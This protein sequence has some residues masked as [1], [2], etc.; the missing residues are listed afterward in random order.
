MYTWAGAWSGLGKSGASMGRLILFSG[1]GLSAESGLPTFRGADGLWNGHKVSEVCDITT[2]RE[3]QELVH[4]FYNARRADAAAA[5]PNAAHRA[6]ADWQ[7][8]YETV[9]LTTN[10]D[11]LLERAGC[12][13]VVHLH[14]SLAEMQ[15][16]ACGGTWACGDEPWRFGDR[17]RAGKRHCTSIR[18]VKPAVVFFHEGAPRYRD[19]HRAFRLLRAEDVVVVV[20][21]SAIVVQVD[22][23]L[24]PWPG[25]KIWV[26][27][28]PLAFGDETFDEAL[29]MTAVEAV[30]R[31]DAMLRERLGHG[32]QAA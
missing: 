22:R 3:N 15:C 24:A 19:M 32:G 27:P 5:R 21:S 6:F 9:N 2:F 20:G 23:Q 28:E 18:A 13:E 11:T 10:V 31:I 4:D 12:P 30:P 25:F 17:C 14:G 8:R 1:A 16:I 29:T 7:S 26:N